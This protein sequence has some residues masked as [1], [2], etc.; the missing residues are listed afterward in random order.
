MRKASR[1]KRKRGI[2]GMTAQRLAEAAVTLTTH[3]EPSA[4]RARVE[5]F[6]EAEYDRAFCG[7]IRA[8]YPVL[9]AATGPDGRVLAAAGCRSARGE[10][11]FLEQYLDDPIEQ[12]V[13]REFGRI[14]E[15]GEI[16]EIGNL[17][18]VSPCASHKLFLALARH[19]RGIGG[20]IAVATATQ[21]LRRSFRRLSFPVTALA[22]ADAARLSAASEDWGGYYQRDPQ[23]L[24]GAIDRALPALTT[25]ISSG[26]ALRLRGAHRAAAEA[27]VSL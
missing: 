24:V 18:S 21:Q 25:G 3:C 13:G 2:A 8:H 15:R 4:A 26:L 7:K 20:T 14:V 1:T 22:R 6:L 5:S 12:V 10:A 19:L 23:V 27:L 17:A 9:I 11:L 16:A